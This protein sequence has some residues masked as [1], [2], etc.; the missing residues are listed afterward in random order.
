[1]APEPAGK[2]AEAPPAPA[3]AAAPQA[4]PVSVDRE[5]PLPSIEPALSGPGSRGAVSWRRQVKVVPGGQGPG[6]RAQ[7]AADPD[8]APTRLSGPPPVPPRRCPSGAGQT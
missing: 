5:R 1:M 4:R 7:E 2:A 3:P 8:R 6:K